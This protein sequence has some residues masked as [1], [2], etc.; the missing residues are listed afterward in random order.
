MFAFLLIV[1]LITK[2]APLI[3]YKIFKA[4]MNVLS[5][6]RFDDEWLHRCALI[7][8]LNAAD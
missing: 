3:I 1:I 4:N 6:R 7:S 2:Q 8:V 5:G